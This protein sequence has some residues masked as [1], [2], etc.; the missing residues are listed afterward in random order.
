MSESEPERPVFVVDTRDIST[1]KAWRT[2]MRW[3]SAKRSDGNE[4]AAAAS[5]LG[6]DE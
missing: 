4:P 3:R 2:V 6:D 5:C 1:E